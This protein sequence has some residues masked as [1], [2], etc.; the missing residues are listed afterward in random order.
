MKLSYEF[1]IGS[2]RAKEKHLFSSSDIEQMLNFKEE[3]ELLNFLKDKGYG[4][5]ETVDEILESNTRKMWGYLESIAP[6]FSVFQP[7]LIQNDT[8]N[9]KTVLK[10]LMFGKVYDDLLISPSVINH[11][12]LKKALENKKFDIFPEWLREPSEKAYQF[13]AKTKDAR[14]SDGV[15]DKAVLERMIYEGKQSK[16][17]FLIEYLN[18]LAFYANIKTALRAAKYHT[19]MEYLEE[20]L[21]ECDGFDRQKVIAKSMSGSDS[22]VKYLEKLSVYDC[23]K[24]MKCFSE[25]TGAFEK[26][27]ENKLLYLAKSMCR[28][29][30]EGCEPLFGYYIGC[31]YERK[32][33]HMIAGGIVTRT[34]PDKIR[35]RLRG[36]YG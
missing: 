25:S 20:S 6:D 29:T 31:K 21:C 8:H 14:L 7:F 19:T 13:I 32:A 10:G 1:S 33:V 18:T 5:G 30:S 27:V 3:T 28:L 15:I 2:V 9:L 17:D 22:L 4:E 34:S 36:L 16:S 24:A 12:E 35:E 26:F 23:N 11:N